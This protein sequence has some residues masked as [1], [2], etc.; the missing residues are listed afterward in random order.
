MGTPIQ[1]LRN[2]FAFSQSGERRVRPRAA[3]VASLASR[4]AESLDPGAK[5]TNYAFESERSMRFCIHPMRPARLYKR[6]D[7]DIFEDEH[8]D[9]PKAYPPS[10]SAFILASGLSAAGFFLP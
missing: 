5:L 4:T 8:G 6:T 10:L 7:D 2:E 1:G 3:G 9:M